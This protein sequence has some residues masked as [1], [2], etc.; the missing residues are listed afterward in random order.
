[1]SM[2][3]VF[4]A[5]DLL[6]SASCARRPYELVPGTVDRV[7][8]S[9]IQMVCK[10]IEEGKG[11]YAAFIEALRRLMAVP[12][13]HDERRPIVGVCGDFYTRITPSGN[14]DL[15]ARLEAMGCQVWPHPYL[16]G[17]L[18][19]GTQLNLNRWLERGQFGLSLLSYLTATGTS[20]LSAPIREAVPKEI[21]RFCL[22]PDPDELRRLSAPYIGPRTNNLIN[23]NVSRIVDFIQRG[24]DGVIS[25]V[26]IGCM[27]GVTVDGAIR[28][29][30][31]DYPEIP[32]V[33]LA[34][35]TNEGPAQRIQLET[36][37]HQVHTLARRRVSE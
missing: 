15:F 22:T 20:T 11:A 31:R 5:I 7:H 13:R 32:M 2:Y 6:L 18:D 19:G 26:G 35:G 21:V 9:N 16:S 30:R 23:E 33:T 10:A 27:V 14:A 24:A 36:F 1:M 3:E 8:T 25:A 28:Q 12:I 34:Y 37:V 4:T 17:L 29:I